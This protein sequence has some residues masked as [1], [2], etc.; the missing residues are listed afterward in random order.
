LVHGLNPRFSQCKKEKD[1]NTK[2]CKDQKEGDFAREFKKE[3]AARIEKSQL[4]SYLE[5]A[6]LDL[7]VKKVVEGCLDTRH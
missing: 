6:H 3:T 7:F 5:V 4:N 2:E 1:E